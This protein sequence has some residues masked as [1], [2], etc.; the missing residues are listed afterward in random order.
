LLQPI[1]TNATKI[2]CDQMNFKPTDILW[3]NLL[4]FD[5]LNNHKVNGSTPIFLRKE[6]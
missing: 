3:D 5:I 2:I 4:E 1:L 6:K